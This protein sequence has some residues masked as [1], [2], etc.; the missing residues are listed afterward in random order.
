[1]LPGAPIILPAATPEGAGNGTGE[2]RFF[3]IL[4][5]AASPATLV[6]ELRRTGFPAGA[7]RAYVLA[8]VLIDH[9]VIVA[10][11]EYPDV[12]E[13]CHLHAAPDLDSALATA[14]AMARARF[15]NEEL[16][17]LAVP[18]ALVTLPRLV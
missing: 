11:A 2:K 15:G 8:K 3:E 13:A 12:V 5:H 9:P 17:L 10:G 6:E 4:S 18:N 14:V 7:Q 16:D 1:L